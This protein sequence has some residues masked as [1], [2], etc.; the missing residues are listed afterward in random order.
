VM[1]G[2]PSKD[3]LAM[4]SR[5]WNGA[6]KVAIVTGPM[7]TGIGFHTARWLAERGC[8]VVLA[9]RNMERLR[10][11][12]QLIKL[13]SK[14]E[15]GQPAAPENL[16]LTPLVLDLSSLSSVE[17]FAHEFR[18]L[19]LPL[20][21]LINNAGIVTGKKFLECPD[22]L[23][24]KTMD[25]NINAHFWTTKA[26]IGP[27]LARNHGHIVS[28]ASMAGIVGVGTLTDYCA[29]K[30]AAVGFSDSLT[31]ELYMTGKTGVHTTTVCPT[32]IDTGMFDGAK[33]DSPNL[34]PLL[35]PEYV[36]DRIMEAVL[37][38]T[39][40]LQLPRFAYFVSFFKGILPV[41]AI[42]LLGDYFGV[43]RSMEHFTGGRG[44]AK[45]T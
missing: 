12:E 25:V 28:I 2:G 11:C 34:L 26:F 14:S 10:E 4:Q 22:A 24:E 17:A 30:F 44:P 35:K 13:Q 18:A 38:N 43:T 37:T 45:T 16:H 8:H 42:M 32:Y 31:A 15:S 41:P 5:E 6:G 33:A 3:T 20:N 19:H 39:P 7:G 40:M 29:S 9:G 1:G 23:I 36:V 27:M 21:L